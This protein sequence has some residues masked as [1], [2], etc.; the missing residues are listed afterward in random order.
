M[1]ISIGLQFFGYQLAKLAQN[2]GAD[3]ASSQDRVSA[4]DPVR[5]TAHAKHD[6]GDI[7]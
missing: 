1:D 2:P 3:A 6:D 7:I 5:L 4:F